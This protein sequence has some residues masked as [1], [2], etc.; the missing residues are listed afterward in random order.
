VEWLKH[1]GP[2]DMIAMPNFIK[3]A[4]LK[5]ALID[6]HAILRESLKLLIYSYIIDCL[7]VLEADDGHSLMDKL[8]VLSVKDLPDVVLL[9]INM[10]HMDGFQTIKWLRKNYPAIKII[11][12]S[13]FSDENTVIRC[14]RLGAHA[15]LVKNV[16]PQEL[17]SAIRIVS[18]KGEYYS[19]YVTGLVVS[20]LK[21]TEFW[22]N[23]SK[24]TN[25]TKKEIEFLRLTCSELSYK[26][27][28]DRMF[29]SPRTVDMYR[30]RLFEKLQ[31]K[32][33][34]GLALYTLKNNLVDL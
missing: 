1:L 33:R 14:L 21:Q 7:I 9:D 17:I 20:S 15:Y 30:I 22:E 5:L 12:L 6:D 31:V 2:V 23:E 32:S 26:E 13:M 11:M 10:P 27:I 28:A 34:V 29:L 4:T 8:R 3:K 25:L 18:E 16:A 19:S 24:Q